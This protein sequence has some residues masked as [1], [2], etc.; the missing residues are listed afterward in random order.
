[1]HDGELYD[2]EDE[3]IEDLYDDDDADADGDGDM[4]DEQGDALLNMGGGDAA[5]DA[6]T[7]G[8]DVCVPA[9]CLS[10]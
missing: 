5:D 8:D 10:E 1:M 3:T 2:S 4:D 7:D 9:S 6:T